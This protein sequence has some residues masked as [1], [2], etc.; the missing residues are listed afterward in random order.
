MISKSTIKATAVASLCLLWL[1]TPI[2]A[3]VLQLVIPD[4]EQVKLPKIVARVS[5]DDQR[6]I[7]TID[8][9]EFGNWLVSTSSPESTGCTDHEISVPCETPIGKFHP[10]RLSE[11]AYSSKWHVP[12]P[13][14]VFIDNNGDAIH[15][16]FGQ[17][18]IN[19]LGH[20][21]SHGCVRLAPDNA[22]IFY[23]LVAAHRRGSSYPGVTIIIQ[24]SSLDWP[25][26]EKDY[27]PLSTNSIPI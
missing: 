25:P 17:D 5:I 14:S 22:K 16:T 21:A 11:H 12:M 3:N 10:T 6:M 7:V 1:I 23:D 19:E 24:Q 15:S 2:S 20:I 18:E 4:H 26:S 9:K 13:D 27:K 8:G